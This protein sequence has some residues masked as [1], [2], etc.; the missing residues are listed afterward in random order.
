[1]FILITIWQVIKI[2]GMNT[3]TPLVY[4]T[5]VEIQVANGTDYKR[6]MS[7]FTSN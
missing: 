7:T 6:S 3:G 4:D 2:F 5:P 1:M